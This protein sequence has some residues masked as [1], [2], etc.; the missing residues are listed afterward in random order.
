MR[1]QKIDPGILFSRKPDRSQPHKILIIVKSVCFSTEVE[2]LK[3]NSELEN[4]VNLLPFT[5]E[6][7]SSLDRAVEKANHRGALP[8]SPKKKLI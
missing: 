6:R 3:F 5:G 2:I 8:N 1:N 7:F 4:L